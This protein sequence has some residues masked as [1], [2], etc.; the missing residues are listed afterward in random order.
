MFAGGNSAGELEYD[1]VLRAR[2]RDVLSADGVAV[3]GGIIKGG[4]VGGGEDFFGD[5]A[6]EGFREGDYF[7]FRC[8]N[9]GEDFLH[10]LFELEHLGR[11]EGR[12]SRVEEKERMNQ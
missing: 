7:G 12:G 1:R 2:R 4:Q 9:G 6:T 3:D 8:R 5:D 11:V 10:S